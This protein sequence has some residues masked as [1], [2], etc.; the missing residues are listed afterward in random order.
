MPWGCD[1]CSPRQRV[2]LVS[3][4]NGDYRGAISVISLHDDRVVGG[5]GEGGRECDLAKVLLTSL[6]P[7]RLSDVINTPGL[8]KVL[9]TADKKCP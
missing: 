8:R 1:N 2:S 5:T 7:A 6:K 4:D 3:L 9:I